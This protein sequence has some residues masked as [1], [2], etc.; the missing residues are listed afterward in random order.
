MSWYNEWWVWM[1][2]ALV[3]AIAEI[4]IQLGSSDAWCAF[5]MIWAGIGWH[6][7][8]M[9]AGYLCCIFVIATICA[10]DFWR[11]SRTSQNLKS[12]S[13]D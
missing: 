6:V 5:L 4:I 12:V 2:A 3:L 10:L 8:G 7:A 1:V 11:A 9:V 13:A